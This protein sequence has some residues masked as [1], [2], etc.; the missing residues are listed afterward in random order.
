MKYFNKLSLL[1]L[2]LIL[3]NSCN[4]KNEIDKDIIY[5]TGPFNE[6]LAGQF[7]GFVQYS[8]LDKF[9]DFGIGTIDG[10]DGE[11]IEID[12]RKYT[13][14]WKGETIQITD[15]VTTP[16]AMKTYFNVDLKQKTDLELSYL[17]LQNYLNEILPNPDKLYAIKITGK[18]KYMKT[19][20]I[21]KQTE[22]YQPLLEALKS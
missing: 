22:P 11:G 21:K 14:N 4:N 1:L 17:E 2:T 5:Q 15:E 20:S 10:L 3:L 9:G 18:F 13:I 7:N 6:L 19:R 8:E 16:F 12:S